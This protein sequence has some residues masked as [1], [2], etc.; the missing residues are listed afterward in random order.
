MLLSEK[1]CRTQGDGQWQQ[2]QNRRHIGQRQVLQGIE[3]AKC[4]AQLTNGADLFSRLEKHEHPIH[5]FAGHVHR[6]GFRQR[7]VE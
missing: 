5:I 1:D 3:K 2:L 7:V 4:G 6:G